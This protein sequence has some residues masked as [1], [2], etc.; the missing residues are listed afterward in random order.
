MFYGN[1]AFQ[2]ELEC[3][4]SFCAVYVQCGLHVH[5]I[6]FAVRTAITLLYAWSVVAVYKHATIREDKV[7]IVQAQCILQ[8]AVC[9]KCICSPHCKYNP[10]IGVCLQCAPRGTADALQ[11]DLR[12]YYFQFERQLPVD[13]AI[14]MHSHASTQLQLPYFFGG[15]ACTILLTLRSRFLFLF[16]KYPLV[17]IGSGV[18]M[19]ISSYNDK[20]FSIHYGP[21]VNKSQFGRYITCTYWAKPR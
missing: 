15:A 14:L 9:Q 12:F 6:G 2:I 11:F 16:Q 4:C 1:K 3:I 10:C 21:S 7:R 20:C 8:S 19:S 18:M 13:E 5:C 17:D